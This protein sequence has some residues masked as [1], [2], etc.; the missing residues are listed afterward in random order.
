MSSSYIQL[1]IYA[2]I[3]VYIIVRQFQERPVQLSSLL[4][5]SGLVLYVSYLNISKEIT[6]ML[7]ASVVLYALL[8]FGLVLGLLLGWYRGGLARLRL[9]ARTG[10]VLA[11]AT[12]FSLMVWLLL[13]IVKVATGVITYT[14]LGHASLFVVLLTTIT[15][16]LF[17]GNVVAEK[18][19][20]LVRASRLSTRKH[21][22]SSLL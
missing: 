17:L 14:V 15:S 16:T 11:K 5:F 18:G 1:L 10:N 13:L 3:F 12:T 22:T 20:L 9:D 6:Q 4:L 8:A 19:R 21:V 7:L 2:V